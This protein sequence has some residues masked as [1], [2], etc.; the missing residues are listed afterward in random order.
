[1]TIYVECQPHKHTHTAAETVRVE[2]CCLDGAVVVSNTIE[3]RESVLW[4]SL[5]IFHGGQFIFPTPASLS[6]QQRK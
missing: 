2:V 1:M 4:K 5:A 3:N 6:K